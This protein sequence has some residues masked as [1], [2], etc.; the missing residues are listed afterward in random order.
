MMIFCAVMI[1]LLLL[2]SACRAKGLFGVPEKIVSLA[3]WIQRL[4]P[5]LILAVV[6]GLVKL[7]RDSC[8]ITLGRV[9]ICI[10]TAA[11]AGVEI[12]LLIQDLGLPSYIQAG[13]VG[14]SG[15]A[16]GEILDILQN[17]LLKATSCYSKKLLVTSGEEPTAKERNASK[18]GSK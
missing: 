1:L 8:K 10:L 13:I 9:F 5:P 18:E 14:V 7:L 15:F 6:G 12:F 2:N 11:F 16:A 4:T 17:S 3:E